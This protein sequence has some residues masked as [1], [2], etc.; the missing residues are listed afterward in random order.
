MIQNRGR[1]QSY[2]LIVVLVSRKKGIASCD[3]TDHLYLPS[4]TRATWSRHNTRAHLHTR[5]DAT[6][7][8][9]NINNN[10]TGRTG[11]CRWARKG[12]SMNG[13]KRIRSLRHKLWVVARID[14]AVLIRQL[15]CIRYT[16]AESISRRTR[17]FALHAKG[18]SHA[19]LLYCH[20]S[21][22]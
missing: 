21:R 12:D 1:K 7:E 4:P 2:Y 3:G 15:F 19:I 16:E 10:Y 8:K 14:A 9:K 5:G 17:P 20:S 13:P 22:P 18:R 6:K 11:L